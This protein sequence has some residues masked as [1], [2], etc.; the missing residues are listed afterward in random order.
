MTSFGRRGKGPGEFEWPSGLAVD[1]SGVVYVCDIVITTVFSYFSTP[2]LNM[3]PVSN[4]FVHH[5]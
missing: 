5:P 1:T 3:C 2:P 4:Y